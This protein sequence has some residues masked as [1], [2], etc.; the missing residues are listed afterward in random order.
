M[1]VL[2]IL[3]GASKGM[4]KAMAEQLLMQGHELLTLSRNPDP[5]L[6]VVAKTSGATLEQ[7]SVDLSEGQKAS[8]NLQTWL[9]RR[10]A[11]EA[12]PEAWVLINNAAALVGM[13]P[14]RIAKA[15]ELAMGLRIGLEAPMQLCAAFLAATEG[16]NA[17]RKILNI[18]SGLGRRAMASAG[19][20]CAIKAGLDHFTRCLALEENGRPEGAKVCSLA[21]GV[22]ATDMQVQLRSASKA[23][24]PDVENFIQ[25]HEK[26]LLD[27]PASA[28]NKLL[29]YLQSPQ[30]GHEAVA[31]IRDIR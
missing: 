22:I 29:A 3:T 7:W 8:Q 14:V 21:P 17:P 30:F 11:Q 12:L 4:G 2:Y 26:G 28:A 1:K 15:E 27:S 20:Y 19:N 25:M 9:E 16:V 24:F 18:S 10:R 6:E 5:Q 13:G 23:L 31:D